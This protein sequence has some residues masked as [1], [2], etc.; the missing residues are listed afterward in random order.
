MLFDNHKPC[1]NRGSSQLYHN[2]ATVLADHE[3]LT[4]NVDT[5]FLNWKFMLE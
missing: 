3:I 4:H 1:H 2:Q 5:A